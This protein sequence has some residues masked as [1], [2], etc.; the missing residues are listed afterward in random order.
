MYCHS[1]LYRYYGFLKGVTILIG[2]TG[3]LISSTLA[4]IILNQVRSTQTWEPA[5][6]GRPIA[7]VVNG[8]PEGKTEHPKTTQGPGVVSL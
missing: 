5:R 2:M 3:G 4:G 1:F 7:A 6:P 8:Q